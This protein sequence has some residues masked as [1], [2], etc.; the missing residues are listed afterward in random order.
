[1]TF[2]RKGE[3]QMDG[4]QLGKNTGADHPERALGVHSNE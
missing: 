2:C 4:H 1:M 3:K